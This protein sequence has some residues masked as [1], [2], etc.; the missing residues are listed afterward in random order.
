MT[1]FIFHVTFWVGPHH[2]DLALYQVLG[3]M[4]LVNVDINFFFSRDH[5]IDASSDFVGWVRSS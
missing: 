5:V 2:P 1:F 3:A 4:N